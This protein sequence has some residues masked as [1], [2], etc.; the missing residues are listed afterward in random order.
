MSIQLD[1]CR[2]SSANFHFVCHKRHF[3][4][5]GRIRMGQSFLRDTGRY[6][7]AMSQV[8]V[9]YDSSSSATVHGLVFGTSSLAPSTGPYSRSYGLPVRCLASGD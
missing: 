7:Y 6:S 3:V 9:D 5:S 2:K 1:I 4:R 8:A